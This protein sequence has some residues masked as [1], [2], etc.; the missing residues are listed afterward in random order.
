MCMFQI[1]MKVLISIAIIFVCAD[2]FLSLPINNNKSYWETPTYFCGSKLPIEM[3]IICNGRYNEDK[4]KYNY[5]KA[6]NYQ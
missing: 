3:A 5:S 6:Y 4:G 2:L 1:I